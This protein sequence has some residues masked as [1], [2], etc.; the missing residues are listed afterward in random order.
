MFRVDNTCTYCV[1][2]QLPVHLVGRS[3]EDDV[4]SLIVSGMCV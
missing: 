2:R 1:A 4:C 3:F